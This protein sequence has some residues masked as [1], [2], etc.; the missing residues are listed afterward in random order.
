MAAQDGRADAQHQ[1]H[2]VV[3]GQPRD[4][5]GIAEDLRAHP[6]NKERISCSKFIWRLRC[7]IMTPVGSRVEPELY[8]RY[9]VW[10]N[11]LSK[12]GSALGVQIHRIDFDDLRNSVQA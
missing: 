10:G 2:V 8:C 3:E 4:P 11:Q 1:T 7:E 9:A 6:R 12:G 5:R